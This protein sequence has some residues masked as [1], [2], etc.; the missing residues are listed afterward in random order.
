VVALLLL[1]ILSFSY[2]SFFLL[3]RARRAEREHEIIARQWREVAGKML[4]SYRQFGF[5]QFLE[6]WRGGRRRDAELMAALLSNGFKEKKGAMFLLNPK[7][8]AEK[9]AAFRKE[10]SDES[11]WFADFVVGEQHLRNGYQEEGLKAYKRSY[12]TI[13]Q[14]PENNQH[15]FDKLLT[16][17]VKARLYDLTAV[18]S[19]DLDK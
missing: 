19:E 2:V 12:E 15:I 18:E 13:L 1:I 17:Q 3:T 7:P 4:T 8:L 10:F 14:L 9:E 6:A 5:V 11:G 16:G